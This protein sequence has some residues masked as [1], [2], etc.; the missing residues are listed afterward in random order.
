MSRLALGASQSEVALDA[1]TCLGVCP[2]RGHF[3]RFFGQSTPSEEP[4]LLPVTRSLGSDPGV[5]AVR[6]V[7]HMSGIISNSGLLIDHC[8]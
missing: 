8:L 1:L 7:P 6:P 2:I 4:I 5:W 3:S